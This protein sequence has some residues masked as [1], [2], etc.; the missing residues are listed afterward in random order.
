MNLFMESLRKSLAHRETVLEKWHK[1]ESSC[2]R[3]FHGA[4][5]GVPGLTVDRYGPSVLFQTWRE[6]LDVSALTS[7]TKMI[8]E[9]CGADLTP[10]WNDRKNR[11]KV[12]HQKVSELASKVLGTE[13]GV[14]YNVNPI[15]EGID[16]LLF[17]DFR[18]GRRWVKENA[19]G[20][21]VLNLF[22]YT[23]G[24][25]VSAMVGGA[26]SVLNVDFSKRALNVG[27]DNAD[28]NGV[29]SKRFRCLHEDFFPVILQL[30][31]KGVRGRAARRS[32]KHMGAQ[33]F[34]LVVLDP[35]RLSKSAFGKVDLVNDYSSL[36]KPALLCVEDGGHC[37]ATNNVASVDEP[38][39]HARLVRCAEKAER[40]VKS[41]VSLT[42]EEDFPSPDNKPPLKIAL[43][44]F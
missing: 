17:L 43:I 36:F 12:E 26:K 5:E 9:W 24:I 25:G 4:T 13:L 15:H 33:R 32:Y 6:P 42:P 1:E 2:Y 14:T 27:M 39:W 41:I 40:P 31:G 28:L 7:A 35:P 11:G 44:E 38:E 29:N 3:V 23:C 10:V 18:V 20:L 34:D 16:P 19:K 8:S 30:S 21:R 37:L 22:S